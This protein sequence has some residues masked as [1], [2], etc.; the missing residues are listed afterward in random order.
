M[1]KIIFL[2]ILTTLSLIS[3]AQITISNN[4]MPSVND[5]YH[6]SITANLQGN[7][8]ILTGTN[9]LWDYSQLQATV[10]RLSLIHI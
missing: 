9:F 1:A 5:I 10:Q 2:L 8:P 3:S 7:N 4:D 6:I